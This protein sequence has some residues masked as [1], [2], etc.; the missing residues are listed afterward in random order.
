MT[1]CPNVEM[2]D[3]LP[4]LLHERL[5]PSTRAAVLA[6]VADCQ[7]CDAELTLL[8]EA[9][10][11]LS[12]GARLIDVTA[13]A[14]AVVEGVPRPGVASGVGYGRWMDWRIAASV[15]LFAVGGASIV[16]LRGHRDG[17]LR[18]PVVAATATPPVAVGSETP[19]AESVASAAATSEGAELSAAGGV[20]DLSDSELQ[21]LVDDL[22]TLDAL[23]PT[24]PE[25]V[26]VRVAVPGSGSS[27]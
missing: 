3:R 16:M 18:A 10:T 1:D 8:R 4:D 24:D 5:D 12:S 6:H 2:R 27:E 14:R 17:A 25:P 20:S 19:P 23:P 15:L 7:D 21:S 11:V 26:N 22:P 9:L 13:V